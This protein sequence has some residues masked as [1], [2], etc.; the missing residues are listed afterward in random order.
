ME[1]PEWKAFHS[2]LF[3]RSRI[4]ATLRSEHRR[5]T[6]HYTYVNIDIPYMPWVIKPSYVKITP[7][8]YWPMYN[9]KQLLNYP[10]STN[11]MIYVNSSCFPSQNQR[12]SNKV[13]CLRLRSKCYK[14]TL[15][16][17]ESRCLDTRSYTLDYSKITATIYN[18][19]ADEHIWWQHPTDKR[20][21]TVKVHM[22]R[23]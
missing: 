6:L 14:K 3:R 9:S 18:I 7:H 19:H 1:Y 8:S 22:G 11:M 12:W 10:I 5:V 2:S 23:W 4:T 20:E 15:P 17:I 21:H 16:E 13:I